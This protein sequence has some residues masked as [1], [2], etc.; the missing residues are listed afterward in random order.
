VSLWSRIACKERQVWV[1]AASGRCKTVPVDAG[2]DDVQRSA[3]LGPISP[4][5]VLVDPVLAERARKLFPDP[6]E[7]PRPRLPLVAAKTS[8]VPVHEPPAIAA[9]PAAPPQKLRW[10][11]TAVL[12]ALIF[13]AGAVSGTFLGGRHASSSPGV[14]FEAQTVASMTTRAGKAKQALTQGASTGGR[15]A[16][17]PPSVSTKSRRPPATSVQRHRRRASRIT[18]AANV[19]GVTARVGT[20]GVTLVWRRPTASGHVVVLRT[21]GARSRGLVVFRGRATSYRDVSARPCTPYRYTI[22][23]YD[24]RGHRSTGV[25]TSVV[26]EGCT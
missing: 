14:T 15:P 7:R 19:L 6:P 20:P 10:G 5:L 13:A 23:N 18:W 4:E 24:R 1:Q 26:T 11:R 12:A 16:L 3:D 9:E 22:V 2:P 21:R 25:P 17:R 8:S